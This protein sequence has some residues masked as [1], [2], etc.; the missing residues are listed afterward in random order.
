MHSLLRSTDMNGAPI[1]RDSEKPFVRFDTETVEN[2]PASQKEGRIV[3]KDVDMVYITVPGSRDIQPE[4]VE[5][6][7][8]KLRTQVASGRLPQEW[9]DGWKRDYERYKQGQEIPLDGTPLKGWTLIPGAAQ[10]TLLDLG[11]LTVEALAG[12]NDE[13]LGRI[14]IGAGLYKRRAEAWVKEHK[15]KEGPAIEIAALRQRNDQLE[16]TVASLTDKLDAVTA[17]L[18]KKGKKSDGV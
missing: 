2:V 10:K 17:S 3:R 11:I 8:G 13:A 16:A 5:D 7:W 18:A 15:D 12:A 6:W 14:G 4:A 9:V 1:I